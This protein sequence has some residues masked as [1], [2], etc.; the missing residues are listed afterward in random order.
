MGGYADKN[1]GN[2]GALYST[3]H[4]QGKDAY[5]ETSGG[6]GARGTDGQD[7]AVIIW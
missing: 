1:A 6:S 4:R 3:Q 2:A 5:H 7:G